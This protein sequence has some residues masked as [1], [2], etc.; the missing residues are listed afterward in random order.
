MAGWC[1]SSSCEKITQ[2]SVL[3]L[4][5]LSCSKW[6]KVVR[7]KT[8]WWSEA[9][10][11]GHFCSASGPAMCWCSFMWVCIVYFG[12]CEGIHQSTCHRGAC[13]GQALE[14]RATCRQVHPKRV[15]MP[16]SSPLL[17]PYSRGHGECEN[18]REQVRDF[19]R[20]MW[21]K[22]VLSSLL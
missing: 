10:L 12:S 20:A 13:E 18:E 1:L 19:N 3:R 5:W 6:E 7:G 8:G 14:C 15:T 4:V 22:R 21:S 11:F 16:L 17:N 9:C 2:T